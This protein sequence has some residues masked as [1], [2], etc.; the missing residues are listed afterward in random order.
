MKNTRWE[1]SNNADIKRLDLL[2]PIVSGNKFYKLKY[3]IEQAKHLGVERVVTFGGA[4]SNHLHAAAWA[5]KENNLQ[6][7][8]LI[9]GEEP[10]HLSPTI[11]DIITWGA[12]VEYI[13]RDAY[14]HKA[15]E[16]F[17]IWIFDTFGPSFI[18]PEGGANFL[19]VN[20]CMEILTPEDQVYSDIF[21]SAGTG[22][23]A[24]GLALSLKPHQ[25]LHVVSALKGGGMKQQMFELIK[26][27]L[28]DDE[29]ASEVLK[30]VVFHEDY[31]F[32][33]YAKTTPEL[34]E[35]IA[36]QKAH[37]DLPL[38]KV[39]TGKLFKAF[40]EIE[41]NNVFEKALIIHSGGLQGNRTISAS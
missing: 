1:S 39:Y 41:K 37:F 36:H 11:I 28:M 10:E 30:N 24:S 18:I 8:A 12:Q 31:H 40:L 14:A 38:D 32:G 16:D 7:I 13:T 34:E 2:H 35:F 9:R 23:M 19:G 20:G 4:Y 25:I 15:T 29:A 21:C 22:T 33:G 5:C 26:Y 6:L 27:F 17:K 3:N